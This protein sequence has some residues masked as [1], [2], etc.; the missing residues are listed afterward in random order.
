MDETK[1]PTRADIAELM[2]VVNPRVGLKAEKKVRN[3]SRLNKVRGFVTPEIFEKIKTDL[4]SYP[5]WEQEVD[6]A[7]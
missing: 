2:G 5:E 1:V 6:D 7:P 3:I 4:P